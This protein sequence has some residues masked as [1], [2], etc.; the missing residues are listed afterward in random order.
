MAGASLRERRQSQSQWDHERKDAV[1]PNEK[2]KVSQTFKGLRHFLVTIV[3]RSYTY[4]T[5]ALYLEYK[6]P[7]LVVQSIC[8]HSTKALYV[9]ILF[10]KRM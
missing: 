8:T 9:W 7:V 6:S 2:L 5:D 4:S 3:P 10:V 1:N